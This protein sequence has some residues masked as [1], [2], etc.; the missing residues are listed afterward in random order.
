TF[1]PTTRRAFQ[2]WMQQQGVALTGRGQDLNAAFAQLYPFATNVDSVLVVLNRD[3]AATSTLLRDG[4]R[5]FSAISRSPT[6]LQQLVENSDRAF[7]ATNAQ[8]AAL[9]QTFRAFPAFLVASRL[10]VNR[11]T[12][13]AR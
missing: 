10:T 9:A 6:A 11:V 1:D 7:S 4:G 8:S 2:T 5:V 13:F 3:S 12:R